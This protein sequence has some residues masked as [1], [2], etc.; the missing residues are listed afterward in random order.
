MRPY[1][2]TAREIRERQRYNK[3]LKRRFHELFIHFME[4]VELSIEAS[5]NKN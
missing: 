5:R 4:L 2:I 3:S 1:K